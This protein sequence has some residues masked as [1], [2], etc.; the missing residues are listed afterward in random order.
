MSGTAVDMYG[1]T[2]SITFVG[3]LSGGG[4]EATGSCTLDNQGEIG[5]GFWSAT[6]DDGDES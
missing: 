4:R 2:Y 5:N 3:S 1:L 6:C